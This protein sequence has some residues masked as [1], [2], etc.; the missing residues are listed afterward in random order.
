MKNFDNLLIQCSMINSIM[1][2]KK[3]SSS[4][5]YELYCHHKYGIRP[6]LLG[7]KQVDRLVRGNLSEKDSV[8]LASIVTGE[9]YYRVKKKVSSEYL[10]GSVDLLDTDSYETATKIIEIK[11][12][13]KLELLPKRIDVGAEKSNIIQLQAYLA[14]TGKKYGE[15]IYCLPKYSDGVIAEQKNLLLFKMC[16]DGVE[17]DKF[18]TKWSIVE[19]KLKFEDIPP[20]DRVVKFS[21]ERDEKIIEEIHESVIWARKYLNKL[22]EKHG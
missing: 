5:L 16:K 3:E 22:Q 4:Y 1:G 19:S 8:R 13:S 7:G 15:L 18:L 6:K 2:V 12:I 17:S 20:K 10:T 9:D 11:T 14:L 21:Y